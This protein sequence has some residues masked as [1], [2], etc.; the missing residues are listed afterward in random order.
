MNTLKTAYDYGYAY[1]SWLHSESIESA[2]IVIARAVSS[3]QPIPDSDSR[4]MTNAGIEPD[5]REYWRGYN[6]FF[7]KLED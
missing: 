2:P 1:A 7:A 4:A 3:T 5:A 6:S